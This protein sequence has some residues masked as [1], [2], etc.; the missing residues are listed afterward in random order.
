MATA[1]ALVQ[2]I[3]RGVIAEIALANGPL[4]LVTRAMLLQLNQA[5]CERA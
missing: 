2:T 3:R 4:N 5:V 1:P